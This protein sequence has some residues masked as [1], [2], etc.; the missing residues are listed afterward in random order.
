MHNAM[1]SQYLLYKIPSSPTTYTCA[2][3]I[4]KTPIFINI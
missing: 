3:F 2:S 1:F 4:Y